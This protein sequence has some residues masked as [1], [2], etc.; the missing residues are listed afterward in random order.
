MKDEG[1]T[2]MDTVRDA[3]RREFLRALTLTTAAWAVS[4]CSPSPVTTTATA[5]SAPVVPTANLPPVWQTVPTI[6]FTQGVAATISISAYVSDPNGDAL[7][8]TK[9]SVALP[10]GITFDS[11]NKRFVYDGVGASGL[12]S[13]NILT[14]DDGRP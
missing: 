1:N 9:N 5:A 4:G 2:T 10:P 14:A 13:G 7:T 11:A 12:S 3:E 6:T 8:I